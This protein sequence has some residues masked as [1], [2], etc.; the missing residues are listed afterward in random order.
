[1]S[2]FWTSFFKNYLGRKSLKQD[3]HL[4]LPSAGRI[5]AACN[6]KKNHSNCIWPFLSVLLNHVYCFEIVPVT[7]RNC[8]ILKI[9]NVLR[10]LELLLIRRLN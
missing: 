5:L 7:Q 3:S 9:G 6:L 2:C 10:F 1:M 4:L 8:N